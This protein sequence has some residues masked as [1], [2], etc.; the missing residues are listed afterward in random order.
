MNDGRILTKIAQSKLFEETVAVQR[1]RAFGSDTNN[2][3]LDK[4]ASSMPV[5]FEAI[6]SKAQEFSSK[7]D[8]FETI[9]TA[10]AVEAIEYALCSSFNPKFAMRIRKILLSNL[11]L[12]GEEAIWSNALQF[13]ALNQQI[14]SSSIYNR[15][16]L[17]R[18]RCHELASQLHTIKALMHQVPDS[19]ATKQ[20][21]DIINFGVG[22][23]GGGENVASG[24]HQSPQVSEN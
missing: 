23:S 22:G 8:I 3:T 11:Y 13:Y 17:Y 7:R 4:K 19:E 2:I 5:M 6:L 18:E 9:P 15:S 21:L 10:C 12:G 14:P 24:P 20:I 16:K 1:A